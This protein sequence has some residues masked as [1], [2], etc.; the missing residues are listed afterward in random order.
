MSRLGKCVCC[1]SSWC[2]DLVKWGYGTG[3]SNTNGAPHTMTSS[4]MIVDCSVNWWLVMTWPC[5]VLLFT[6][7]PRFLWP[8]RLMYTVSKSHFTCAMMTLWWNNC[9]L[10]NDVLL[11]ITNCRRIFGHSTGTN[12]IGLQKK[13]VSSQHNTIC[14]R[15]L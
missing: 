11:R 15:I 13:N 8:S 6:N 4:A 2:H 10:F 9:F 1:Y 3:T 7:C 14:T 12:S 5:W